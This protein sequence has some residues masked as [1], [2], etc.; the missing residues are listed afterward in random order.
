MT[1][2]DEYFEYTEKYKEMYGEKTLVLIQ[3]GSFFEVYGTTHQGA[4]VEEICG[5]INI[6]MTR[7]N[8]SNTEITRKNPNMCGIPTYMLKKYVDILVSENYT[9]IIIEQVTEPPEPERKV[10]NIIS[11][12]TYIDEQINT[13]EN[14]YLMSLYITTGYSSKKEYITGACSWIDVN[15]NKNYVYE[16]ASCIQDTIMSLEDIQRLI[17]LNRPREIVVFTDVKTK[18]MKDF[19]MVKEFIE[20]LNVPCVHNKLNN[21]IDENYFKIAYQT[22]VLKKVFPKVGLLSHIEYVNLE[23]RPNALVS[24]VYNIQFIYSHN[25]K[26]IEGLPKPIII[27]NKASL[28]LINSCLHNLNIISKN[29]KG[30]NTSLESI[31]NNCVTN[32]GKRYF[33]ECITNPLTDEKEINNRYDLI[34]IFKKNNL[35]VSVKKELHQIS[36]LERLLKR[37]IIKTLEPSEFNLIYTSLLSVIELY[38]LCRESIVKLGWSEEK[39]KTLIEMKE[40]LDKTFNFL[41]MSNVNLNQVTKNL[42]LKDVYPEI[43]MMEV[44]LSNLD[45]GFQNVCNCLNENKVDSEFR[46]EVSAKNERK[47]LVTKKRF[48]KLTNDKERIRRIDTLLKKNCNLSYS[49]IESKPVSSGKDSAIRI[50]FKGMLENQSDLL[51]L[52]YEFRSLIQEEYLSH[53]QFI[54]DKYHDY[55]KD[56]IKFIANIDFFCCCAQNSKKYCYVRPIIEK[57][58]ESY[59]ESKNI[60]HPIVEI[61][62]TNIPFVGNDVTIGREKEKGILLYGLNSVGKSTL[63]KSVAVNLILAQAGMFVAADT[64]KYSPY[65]SVFTRIPNGDNLFKSQS[66]FT[67]EINELRTILNRADKKSLVIGDELCSGTESISAISLVS[68]GINFLSQKKTSFIFATHLH[69]I[70]KLSCINELSN[71]NIFH[72]SVFFDNEKNCLIYDRKLKK[73]NGETLYGLEVA[74][75]LDLPL[76]FLNFANEVRQKYIGIEKNFLNTKKSTFSS[77]IYMDKCEICNKKCQE[78]HHIVEQ[79]TANVDGILEKEKIHKNRKSN[80]I[81]VCAE[82]HDSIHNKEIKINGFQQSSVGVELNWENKKNN[83]DQISLEQRVKTLRNKGNTYNYIFNIIQKEFAQEKVTLYK[84]KKICK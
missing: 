29:C 72:L 23:L 56:I 54:F 62:N 78:T 53:L 25:E 59:I 66:T 20:T 40:Y 1:I 51:D 34:D 33:K 57:S 37:L 41:E 69:E 61:I 13:V 64:F 48:E 31:L 14:N 50:T 32:I 15:T 38:E 70:T 49:D 30:K 77:D 76:D 12:S 9:L 73:G 58:E 8:K 83:E 11:P 79:H 26:I 24:F 17:T 71:V 4:N 80:L 6:Q 60:R 42:F 16:I 10:T 5:I 81:T 35:Y 75:S 27:E 19:Q 28:S 44:Q 47:I 43:D 67:A 45:E 22:S 52:Q 63:M 74:K 2:I 21:L 82:C 3:I 65:N 84:I 46:L 7:K 18:K 55:V 39:Q 36:D 68:S